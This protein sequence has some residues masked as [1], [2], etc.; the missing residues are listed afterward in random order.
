[1]IENKLDLFDYAYILQVDGDGETTE[2]L[3]MFDH[4]RFLVDGTMERGCHP[5]LTIQFAPS[6][7]NQGK[8]WDG[9]PF[10][11]MLVQGN[12]SVAEGRRDNLVHFPPLI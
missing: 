8:L 11:E 10:T 7:K 6:S 3:T 2:A 5:L 4:D 12:I 9:V 1:M